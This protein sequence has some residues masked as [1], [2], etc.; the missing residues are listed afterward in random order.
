MLLG[1]KQHLN[2]CH[3]KLSDL[4]KAGIIERFRGAAMLNSLGDCA[5]FFVQ[6]AVMCQELSLRQ[7]PP[8]SGTNTPEESSASFYRHCFAQT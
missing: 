7:Y 5:V 8:V 1:A 4:G 2:E 3:M 6:V